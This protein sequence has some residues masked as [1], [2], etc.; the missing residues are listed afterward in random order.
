MPTNTQLFL[1]LLLPA[2]VCG[3]IILTFAY[4]SRGNKEKIYLQWG[5]AI[6]LGLG[7]II[8]YI[9]IEGKPTF[10]PRESIHW[11]FFL[12][13]I[14]TT[15]STY[16]HLHSLRSVVSKLLYSII[17][18]RFLLNSYFKQNWG[19]IEG[20]IWWV[21][22]STAIFTV[23]I[24]IQYSFSEL[25]SD[26]S[27]SFVYLGLSGGTALILAFSGS[28]RYGQH[29][30]VLVALFATFYILAFVVL[31]LNSVDSNSPT[32]VITVCI[33]PVVAILLVTIWINGYFY[34]EV[35]AV[36]VLLLTI[37]PLMVQ[38]DRIQVV[39]N[40]GIRKSRF[41]QIGLTA[42]CVSIALVIAVIRSGF[43]GENL[44]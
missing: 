24:I 7:Y 36:S 4:I 43:F 39:K 11:I 10:P 21:C 15:S 8:G 38:I 6:A 44:Y 25:S 26:A 41:V 17:L 42:L 5:A 19:P 1:S 23:F 2:I 20:V 13:I 34:T 22:L 33:S 3:G 16:W 9:G 14:A 40:L 30:A 28:T 32:H 18:P 29:A 35:P 37:S 31:R 12:V 27:S